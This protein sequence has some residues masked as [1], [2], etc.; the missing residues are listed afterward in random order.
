MG[1]GTIRLARSRS[2]GSSLWGDMI[3]AWNDHKPRVLTEL[4]ASSI[5]VVI[6]ATEAI[7]ITAH[8]NKGP[9]SLNTTHEQ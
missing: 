5:G 1:S 3:R 2:Q 8:P 9:K 6:L 4:H 7:V